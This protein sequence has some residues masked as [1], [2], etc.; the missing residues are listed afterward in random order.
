MLDELWM[1]LPSTVYSLVLFLLPATLGDI[2]S[3]LML[4]SD[5]QYGT[6]PVFLFAFILITIG[7]PSSLSNS[8]TENAWFGF[9]CY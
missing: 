3:V 7:F 6:N 5:R 2:G 8:F 4:T 1:W 9:F